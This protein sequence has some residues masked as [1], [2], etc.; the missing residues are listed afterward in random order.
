MT[1]RDLHNNIKVTQVL[2]PVLATGATDKTS[3]EIDTAGFQSLELIAHFG[4]A[5]DT[6]S[7][8]Q[9]FEAEVQ[10]SDTSGSG[11]AACADSD[12]ISSVTG[13]NTGCFAVVDASGEAG[14]SYKTGYIGSKRYVKV[15]INPTGSN[16]TG[17]IVGATAIQGHALNKP[18]S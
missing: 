15:V 5:G 8:S 12:L 16:S 4:A 1:T 14:Q 2:D 13:T 6:L 17:T 9:K 18:V 3:N 7:G 11:Y 10:H